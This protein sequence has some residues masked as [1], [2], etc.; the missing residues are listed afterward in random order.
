MVSSHNIYMHGA[1]WLRKN[2]ES[3]DGDLIFGAYNIRFKDI[4]IQCVESIIF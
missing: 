4:L 2:R 3:I 1:A